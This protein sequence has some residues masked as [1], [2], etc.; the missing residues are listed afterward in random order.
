[1]VDMETNSL[2]NPVP[3][4]QPSTQWEMYPW[5]LL[6][7]N[8]WQA[9]V[10]QALATPVNS[11]LEFKE[12]ATGNASN[13]SIVDEYMM[14]LV[15]LNLTAQ[16][17]SSL[18]P[19]SNATLTPDKLESVVAQAAAQVIW[20]AGQIGSSNGGLDIGNGTADAIQEIIALRLNVNFLPLVFAASASIIMVGLA[21]YMTRAD[22]SHDTQSVIPNTGAL[23]LLWLGRHSVPIHDTLEDVE[24]PTD[25]NL[26]RA[27]MVDVCF[28]KT[29]SDE[30]DRLSMQSST[31]SLSGHQ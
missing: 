6:Q 2:W 9:E 7:S 10:G 11:G 20:I 22:T 16:Y 21:L 12:F 28:A 14:S 5:T 8:P 31:D 26:R 24:D 19:V 23:Q 18:P 1:M 3:I 17:L 4:S 27:G 15:G 25:V 30:E 13:P 29:T